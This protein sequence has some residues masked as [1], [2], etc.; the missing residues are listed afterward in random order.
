MNK[1]RIIL[2]SQSTLTKVESDM[3]M[4]ELKKLDNF[5]FVVDFSISIGVEDDN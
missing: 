2:K 5:V 4:D 1:K 3:I